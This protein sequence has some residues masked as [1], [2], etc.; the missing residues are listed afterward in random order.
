MRKG[1]WVFAVFFMVVQSSS[2]Q[3]TADAIR[4]YEAKD[5]TNDKIRQL[6]RAQDRQSS[7][8]AS[9]SV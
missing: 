1:A 6:E 2:K 3:N 7:G 5:I 4:A 9:R 8:G